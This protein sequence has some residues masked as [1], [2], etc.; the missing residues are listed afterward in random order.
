MRKP[1]LLGLAGYG[2]GDEARVLS[3]VG[4]EG[5]DLEEGGVE[6]IINA[7]LFH[8]LAEDGAGDRRDDLRGSATVGGEAAETDRVGAGEDFSVVV[9]G[10]SDDL[11]GVVNVR[12]VEL[13]AVVLVF[14]GTVDDVAEMEEEG[15]GVGGMGDVE[16]G[17]HGFGD[18]TLGC[19]GTFASISD[20]VKTNGAGRF[21]LL[22][23]FL[24]DDLGEGEER[25]ACGRRDGLEV[26][27]DK[28]EQSGSD[29]GDGCAL[30]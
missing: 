16:V 10:D 18:G 8:G 19:I 15:G 27:L 28:I 26:S 14:V 29:T 6:E 25:C 21:N 24:A 20:G 4:I 23:T 7:G 17:L 12:L 9:A 3:S 1:G 2:A 22:T 5:D 11:A 30:R 13:G